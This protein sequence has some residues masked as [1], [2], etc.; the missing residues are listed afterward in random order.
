M[1]TTVVKTLKYIGLISVVFITS[2]SC[3]K[4]IESIGVNLVDNNTFSTGKHISEVITTTENIEKVPANSVSQYLLG[5]Y[6]D[7]EFGRLNGSIVG[8]ISLPLV[9][10]NY[11]Y[12]EN[13][14]V[15]SVLI[16]IPYQATKIDNFADGKPQFTLDSIFGDTDLEFNLE[17]YEL[18]TF[19][20]NLDPND[21]S[22]SAIY[23]SDKEFQKGDS[24]F[25]SGSFK[26]NPNDTVAYINRYLADGI[27]LYDRD[28]IK[29]ADLRPTI[30]IPLDEDLITQQFVEN[31]S[32]GNFDSFEAFSHYFRG[33]YLKAMEWCRNNPRIQHQAGY[34]FVKASRLSVPPR[35]V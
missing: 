18:K 20:N 5:S 15:D 8:Q 13:A 22:K 25:F 6:A 14:L 19:L 35:T 4:E 32:S 21:P 17:V 9:G 7:P 26:V 24:P 16:N 34:H 2:L 10:S 23:Y 30:K 33:F 11:N 1:T 12:G 3:E 29:E 27:T 31:A 28:T